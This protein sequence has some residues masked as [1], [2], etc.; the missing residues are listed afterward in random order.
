MDIF[1]CLKEECV[2]VGSSSTNKDGVLREL[3]KLAKKSSALDAISEDDLFTA[4][5]ERE[6]I[7]STGFENGIAIP[8]C[9]LSGVSEFTV[10]LLIVP[11]GVDFSAYDGQPSKIIFV[12]VAPDS[13]RDSHIRLLSTIS[14]T[15]NNADVR[16]EIISKTTP[17]EVRET[18]LRHASGDVAKPSEEK[19]IFHI[20]LQK[21]DKLNDILQALSSLSASVTVVESHDIGSYLHSLPLFASFW[22]SEEKGFHILAVGVINKKLVNEL[23]RNVDTI[24]GGLAGNPGTMVT[25]QEVLISAGSLN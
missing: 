9:R 6:K 18:F 25:I 7:G 16:K 17:V 8:H 3:A 19:C 22:N 24:V 5:I 11:E 10:G 21:E 4:L 15:L 20:A 23:I 1:D 13:D 2:Q 14:R 12:I